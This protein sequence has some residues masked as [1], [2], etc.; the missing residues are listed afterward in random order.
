MG[1]Q[2]GGI[3]TAQVAPSQG[4]GLSPADLGPTQMAAPMAEPGAIGAGDFAAGAPQVVSPQ[5]VPQGIPEL[6]PRKQLG[7]TMIDPNLS[8]AYQSIKT[9]DPGYQ[10]NIA[11]R[12]DVVST[13]GARLKRAQEAWEASR[14]VMPRLETME[15]ML[16]SGVETGKLEEVMLPIR[17]M[18]AG[19]GF[20][21]ADKIGQQEVFQAAANFIVP[22]MR[23][24]G[25]GATS[26]FEA[27]LF[28]SA[29]PTLGKLPWANKV[30]IKMMKGTATKSRQFAE[31]LAKWRDAHTGSDRGFD[32][33][34][35]DNFDKPVF[36][37]FESIESAEQAARS[38]RIKKGDVVIIKTPQGY[39][40]AEWN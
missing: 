6:S 4:V 21:N 2:T 31:E 13:A 14:A 28:A 33:Y 20:A 37:K 19:M 29:A 11:Y 23:V 1:G 5:P 36:D 24:A 27:Q 8:R 26:D 10:Q 34:W 25:S 9:S 40:F 39:D 32:K 17:Q 18:L 35:A 16:A 30:L 7:M 38:G 22:R 3:P 12:K 15:T